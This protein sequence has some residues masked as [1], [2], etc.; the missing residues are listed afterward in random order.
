MNSGGAVYF[1][2]RIKQLPRSGRG[3][4]G[5]YFKKR[6]LRRMDAISYDHDAYG[7]VRDDYVPKHR[8]ST[9]EDWKRFATRAGNETIFKHSVTLLDNIDRIVVGTESERQNLLNVFKKHNISRLP[10]GRKIDEM[11]FI[12]K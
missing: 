4:K 10:D 2:T 9:P 12:G 1:F 11:V 5:L 7:K 8:G 6:L 3:P